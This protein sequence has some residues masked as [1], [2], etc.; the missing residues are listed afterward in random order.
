MMRF[1]HEEAARGEPG[2]VRS[3][4]GI[5]A[6]DFTVER[7]GAVEHAA[8][9]TLSLTLRVT[10][11]GDEPIRFVALTTQIRIAATKRG[12][13]PG[14]KARLV[15]LFGEPYRWPTTVNSVFWTQVTLLIPAFAGEIFVDLPVQCSYDM[16]VAAAKYFHGVTGGEVPLELL[17]SGTIFYSGDGG[18]LQTVRIAMDREA[19]FRLPVSVWKE[20]MDH[21]F[22]DSAWLRLRKDLFDQLREYRAS[23]TLGTWDAAIEA[24]LRATQNRPPG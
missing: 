6:L 1:A 4:R 16:D 2:A 14:E 22:P 8:A 3:V 23:H 11:R 21:Y 12:Y 20:M 17:F 10:N 5:P 19:A 13:E 9:P 7:A 24:L 18:E 15:E